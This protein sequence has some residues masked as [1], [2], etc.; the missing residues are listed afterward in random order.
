MIKLTRPSCPNPTALLNG[1]YKHKENKIALQH[2]NYDK[3]MYCESKVTHTYYGDVEHIKP[4]S[5]FSELEFVWENL[6]YVCAK[7]NGTKLD[8]YNNECPYIDPYLENPDDHVV[9]IGTLLKQK[10]GSEKG[11]LTII[12]IDLNRK[13]LIERRK[14]K[15]DDLEKAI[16]ACFRTQNSSLRE[17]ALGSLVE[18]SNDDKEYSLFV[19]SLLRSHGII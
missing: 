14:E 2:A 17:N 13:E 16:N 5:K 15:I 11:E 10:R 1:D 6:G 18:E 12:D 4:K 8:K 9:A 19:K 3:C 7:C